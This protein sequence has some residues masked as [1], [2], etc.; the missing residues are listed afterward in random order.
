V[1]HTTDIPTKQRAEMKLTAENVAIRYPNV[2]DGTWHAAVS[3]ATFSVAEGSFVSIIG[4]SGCGKSSLLRAVAGL[5]THHKGKLVLN[6]KAIDGP[7][8]DRAMVFQSALLL[9][10]RSIL[11]NVTLGLEVRGINYKEAESRAREVIDLVGLKGYEDAY[12]AA[13]SGG[14]QQRVNIARALILDPDLLLLDE[15]FSALD[16]QTRE[17][18]GNELIRILAI[19]NRTALF[20]THQIEEAV[21]LSDQV[22]VLSRGPGST[23][24]RIVEVDLPRP[25]TAETREDPKFV[26]LV[27]EL[28][29]DIFSVMAA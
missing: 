4:P 1:T 22:V 28:R 20:V 12:P 8:S 26:H 6:G 15:P 29:A 9:P 3:D 23:I 17:I 16:A 7:G 18:M 19:E 14:M 24:H 27:A 2:K 25:R 13:L 10:W 5:T 11:R 21:F